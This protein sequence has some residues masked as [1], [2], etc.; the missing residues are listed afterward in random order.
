MSADRQSLAWMNTDGFVSLPGVAGPLHGLQRGEFN[1]YYAPG[2]L[3]CA[4][5]SFAPGIEQRIHDPQLS[6]H[7]VEVDTLLAHSLRAR[8]EWQT[9]LERPYE[10]VSLHLYLNR[11][12]QLDCRYCYSDLPDATDLAEI[13]TTAIH[14]AARVVAQNCADKS[15]PLVVV[16]HGG[17]EP[18]L[19]WRLID[20]LQP[21]LHQLAASHEIPLFRYIS[22]NGVMSEQRALWLAHSFELVG[23]SI[24]GPPDI[25]K[26]QRPLRHN[27]GNSTSA[28]LRTAQI[29]R[30][31]GCP[32]HV[33]VTLTA[34]SA[35]R[36]V[37]ICQY[38]CENLA[39]HSISVEPVYLG[40]RA[41][42]TMLIRSEHLDDFVEAFFQARATAH[43]YGTDWQ[44]AAVRPAEVHGPYCNIFRQVLQLIPGD[45]V[46]AC[47]K[48]TS[49]SQAGERGMCVGH[50]DGTLNL[51]RKR[52]LALQA[53]CIRP[54]I[55]EDCLLGYHCTYN[56][57]NACL[58]SNERET[59]LL[60]QLLKRI[61][62]QRLLLLASELMR[63]PGPL[64]GMVITSA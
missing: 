24:D 8:R 62:E 31:S 50:F 39:P 23:L 21:E 43:R 34:W 4:E 18:V 6:P 11:R 28:I 40:G 41:D 38:L 32:V 48:D 1:L 58:L 42:S 5:R 16:F 7:Y 47:F 37:E 35:S 60:C 14:A 13:S 30:E 19:S 15:L 57:P 54:A 29:L 3:L 12:C 36:Q 52:I 22:T 59:D 10:P 25:Q 55:C 61:F 46:S 27:A 33:R 45:I 20:S 64:S 9:L 26:F 49:P 51:D 17:G 44:I 56:C 53:A 2:Y 63:S